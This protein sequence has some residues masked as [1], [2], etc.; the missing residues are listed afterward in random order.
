MDTLK[1]IDGKDFQKSFEANMVRLAFFSRE[2]KFEVNLN[3]I[4]NKLCLDVFTIQRLEKL[5]V[6]SEKKGSG[7]ILSYLRDL[8]EGDEKFDGKVLEDMELLIKVWDD[9]YALDNTYKSVL[10]ECVV[11]LRNNDL[12]SIRTLNEFLIFYKNQ[13]KEDI[14]I[15]EFKMREY[16]KYIIDIGEDTKDTTLFSFLRS[17]IYFCLKLRNHIQTNNKKEYKEHI[18]FISNLIEHWHY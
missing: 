4:K 18:D 16:N 17:N 11:L 10:N 2:V 6:D 13:F 15:L 7:I 12:K 5:K 8:D 3:S 9:F 1:T 14:E